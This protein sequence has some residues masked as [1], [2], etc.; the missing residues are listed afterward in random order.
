MIKLLYTHKYIVLSIFITILFVF[1]I[2]FYINY[3]KND[4]VLISTLEKEEVFYQID[5]KGEVNSPGVYTLDVDANVK[6][7]ITLAGGFTDNAYTTNINLSKS[8]EDEMA[9][10]VYHKDALN[11][12][13]NINI[14]DDNKLMTLPGIGATKAKAIIDFRINNGLFESKEE[15]MLVSGIG[16]STYEKIKDL[17]YI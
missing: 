12:L 4:T 9:I 10:I 17:I 7:V 16:E 15:I 2:Y 1:S 8:V 3:K 14:A 13:V 6:D 11:T 5:V